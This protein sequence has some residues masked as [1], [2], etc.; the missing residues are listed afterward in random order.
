MSA[1]ILIAEDDAVSRQMF[2]EA[3]GSAGYE[4]RCAANGAE[5]IALLR[6]LKPSL[7][8]VDVRMP[9][10]G[11]LEVTR[12]A[13]G[14]FPNMPIVVM[15]AFGSMDTAIEAIQEGAFDFIAKPVNL[16]ELKRIVTRALS[17]REPR[18]RSRD[19]ASGSDNGQ[20]LVIGKSPA[21][22]DV[23]KTIARVAPTKSTVLILGESGTG[24]ELIARAIHDHSPKADKS[25]VAVDCGALTETLLA[26]ELFGHVRGAF[27]GAVADKKGAFEEAD[28]GTCFLDEIGN[29]NLETQAKLLRVLQEHEIKRVGSQKPIKVDVRV[30]AA[31]NKDL[32]QLIKTGAF[33]EDLYYR[34][35]VITIKLP[36]L[37]A[38]RDDIPRL[39]NHFLARFARENDK[40][41]AAIS[42]AAMEILL[43]Y[44]WP[45]NIRELENVIE[46]TVVLSNQTTVTPDDLP[47]DISESDATEHEAPAENGNFLLSDVPPL[48]ELKKRY[49][50]HVLRR[51]QGNVSRAAKLLKVDR[52]SL[53]RML[54]RY[55]L[56]PRP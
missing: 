8:I 54:E 22:F 40:P 3:L 47:P 36:P 35:K 45:G 2:A 24:K 14:D 31:T 51:T 53:Y 44:D 52:R 12:L 49:L 38:R 7:L 21:M 37:R 29:I 10:V 20:E 13:H 17:Q 56:Q 11:G 15:T 23:Y 5:T 25:F 46:R 9:A 33:R 1:T 48:E 42:E 50:V 34:I 41:V 39:A 4:T 18:N 43:H 30:I 32:K 28:G 6:E 19:S 55:N 16:D 26:S 27:T